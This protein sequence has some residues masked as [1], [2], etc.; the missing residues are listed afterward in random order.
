M[1][2][3]SIKRDIY[4]YLFGLVFSLTAV[5]AL[6][7]NQSYQVGLNESAKYGFLYEM[8]LAEKTFLDSGQLPQ[9]KTSTLQ[10]YTDLADV[11][12]KFI[13]A[14]DWQN[15]DNNQIEELYLAGEGGQLGEYLYAGLH[16]V[17]SQDQY[18]YVVSQYDEAIYL[19]LFEQSPPESV[20][21][22]NT[23]FLMIL[24][25]LLSVFLLVRLLIHRI[26]NPILILSKWSESLDLNQIEKISQFRYK[27]VHLLSQQLIKSV[28]QQRESIEREEFF[29]R[30]ASHELRTPVS[31]I[32]ASGEM[33][34]RL[35]PSMTKSAQRA[36]ARI[37]RSVTTIQNL[38]NT[39]LWMSRNQPTELDLTPIELNKMMSNIVSNHAYL[40][41]GKEIAIK[42]ESASTITTQPLPP[43]L[44][45][46]VLSNLIRNAFQHTAQGEIDITLSPDMV[47]VTNSLDESEKNN[48]ETSFGIGLLLIERLCQSQDWQFKKIQN[49]EGYTATVIFSSSH[50]NKVTKT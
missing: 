17:A 35:S 48:L 5:Y 24:V 9:D 1:T 49:T 39:L 18:L 41:D 46:I 40:I 22:F 16:Y 28:I 36:I 43:V 20:S 21:Q 12:D 6:M 4:L 13:Q 42:Q 7:V 25:L 10:I 23:A 33:L 3:V 38:I 14:F 32:S 37:N 15:I 19:D 50:P 27:E 34:D 45:N 29:L 2:R 31:I 47:Q 44:V 30:A 11:P 8:T 26:T